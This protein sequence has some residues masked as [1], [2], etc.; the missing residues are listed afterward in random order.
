MRLKC[1]AKYLD[2]R[3]D[4]AHWVTLIEADLIARRAFE[5]YYLERPQSIHVH[6]IGARIP[7]WVGIGIEPRQ[8]GH[9]VRQVVRKIVNVARRHF[10]CSSFTKPSWICLSQIRRFSSSGRA[11]NCKPPAGM[12]LKPYRPMLRLMALTIPTKPSSSGWIP[13]FRSTHSAIGANGGRRAPGRRP[14]WITIP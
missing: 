7:G 11:K 12:D 4:M 10:F 2:V 13:R 3:V 8:A 5:T 9:A 14:S 1:F 6:R